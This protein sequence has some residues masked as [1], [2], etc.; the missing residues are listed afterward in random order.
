MQEIRFQIGIRIENFP[1]FVSTKVRYYSDDVIVNDTKWY[2]ALSL[3]KYC[4]NEKKYIHVTPS[5]NDQP[6][7]LGAGIF[8]KRSDAKD[9]SFIVNAPFKFKQPSQS[10]VKGFRF[11]GRKFCLNTTNNYH[12]G[13]GIDKIAK[14][15]V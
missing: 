15:D 10:Q 2:I 8:G 13:W 9:C 3:T 6:E 4:K 11:F 12:Q 14:I 1:S 5:S 7:A